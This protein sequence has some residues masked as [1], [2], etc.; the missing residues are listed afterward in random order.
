MNLTQMASDAVKNFA[1]Q[2][3]CSLAID[4]TCGNGFDTLNLAQ[5]LAKPAKVFA[6]DIQIQA[7]LNSK[8]LVSENKLSDF[9]EFF[10]Q[11]HST[12]TSA[13][14][15]EFWGKI[16]IAMFNLGWLPRSDKHLI[17][18]PETTIPALESL[19]LLL[20][21]STNLVSVL[22]YKAHEGGENEFEVVS[23]YIAQFN[24]KIYTDQ[25]NPKSPVLFLY[26][27]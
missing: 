3:N 16:N 14:N 7:I 2:N 5:A 15:K 17:T 21:K 1:L 19:N 11:S 18:K 13:I 10:N 27:I 26:S 12:M 20:D 6:F 25:N 24:P 23:N 4:A 22:S 9:V 8:K